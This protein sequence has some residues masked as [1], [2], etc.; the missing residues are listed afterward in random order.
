[1]PGLTKVWSKSWR[2]VDLASQNLQ[3]TAPHCQTCY[4]DCSAAV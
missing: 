2:S 3:L 4:T 1:L